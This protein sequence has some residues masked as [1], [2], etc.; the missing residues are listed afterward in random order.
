MARTSIE[1]LDGLLLKLESLGG[2]TEK[3]LEKGIDK[4]VRRVKRDAKLLAPVDTGR[5]RN[6]IQH[7]TTNDSGKIEG[8]VSTNVKYAPYVEFGTGQR[9]ENAQIDRPEGIS[10]RQDWTG[11]DPQPFLFPALVQ[12]QSNIKKDIISEV[13]KA[14]KEVCEK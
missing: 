3:A 6:S 13:K 11:Q 4:A 1:G 12:N 2:N 7:K 8:I 14:I 10:Y 5:L 9:G